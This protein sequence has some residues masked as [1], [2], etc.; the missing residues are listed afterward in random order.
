MNIFTFDIDWAPEKVI[1]DVAALLD[2]HGIS[3]TFFATHSSEVL[4]AIENKGSH[5]IGIHPNFNRLLNGE[6]GNYQKIIDELLSIYPSAIGMRAHSLLH[7]C[8]MLL[9]C[10]DKGIKYDSNIYIPFGKEIK[11]FRYFGLL[12]IPYNWEDDGQW[13]A[14]KSFKYPGVKVDAEIN[15]FSFHPIHVYL[16]THNQQMYDSVKQFYQVPEELLE[17]R[18]E[19]IPGVRDLFLALLKLCKENKIPT[20]TLKEYYLQVDKNLELL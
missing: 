3:G 2:Q 1:E 9:Y 5:E 7:S 15:I 8:P 13:V 6:P 12:R 10:L 11:A 4:K 20:C 19:D 16:N 18:N 14:G 17:R